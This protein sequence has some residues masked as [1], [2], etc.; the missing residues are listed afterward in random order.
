MNLDEKYPNYYDEEECSSCDSTC[1]SCDNPEGCNYCDT[2]DSEC[3]SYC[4]SCDE[5]QGCNWC[6]SND[7]C[8]ICESCDTDCQSK[9]T[10]DNEQTCSTGTQSCNNCDM[11]DSIDS[12]VCGQTCTFADTGCGS[13]QDSDYCGTCDISNQGCENC[14][15]NYTECTTEGGGCGYCQS[16]LCSICET[17]GQGNSCTSSDSVCSSCVNEQCGTC[18][19]LLS[20]DGGST[21]S[22]NK[23]I[24]TVILKNTNS[25]YLSLFTKT[26]ISEGEIIYETDI[27]TKDITPLNHTYIYSSPSFPIIMY[28]NETVVL[29]YKNSASS[30]TPIPPIEEDNENITSIGQLYKN[31][32]K[33]APK[34]TYTKILV[35]S[36]NEESFIQIGKSV[37]NSLAN[38]ALYFTY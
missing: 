8:A 17:G 33:F 20:D 36:E 2:D 16:G 23:Y 37:P 22:G 32:N 9:D 12:S 30:E 29:Y 14:E 18:Q 31:G 35:N 26:N 15:S 27:V 24:L 19:I 21:P 38:G 25:E 1:D 13:G 7:A 34:T 5:K 3:D 28:K 6:D 10:C 11:C 4:D